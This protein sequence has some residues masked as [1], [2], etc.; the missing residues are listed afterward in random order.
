MTQ[1]TLLTPEETEICGCVADNRLMLSNFFDKFVLAVQ[2]FELLERGG[3]PPTVGVFGGIFS[4]FRV[5]AAKEGAMNI[6]HFRCTLDAIRKQIGR[7]PTTRDTVDA[8]LVKKAVGLFTRH[9]PNTNNIRHAIAHAGEKFVSPGKAKQHRQKEAHV[10]ASGG[11]SGAG[12][13]LDAALFNRTY[14]VGWEGAVF[15]LQIDES[16][17]AKLAEIMNLALSAFPQSPAAP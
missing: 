8:L 17:I 1:D 2:L 16:S 14:S 12:G 10:R 3:G 13:V 5:I 11:M 4:Q 15:E 6:Y 7:C 9:F